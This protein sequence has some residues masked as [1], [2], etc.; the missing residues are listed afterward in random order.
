LPSNLI[1]TR[2]LKIPQGAARNYTLTAYDVTLDEEGNEVS[3]ARTDLTGATVSFRVT[4]DS[5][6]VTVILKTSAD[7]NEIEIATD[8]TAGQPQAT[9]TRGQATLK[10]VS[11]D[12]SGMDPDLAYIYDVWVELT[13]GR[14]DTIIDRSKFTVLDAV[15]EVV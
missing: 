10:L 14:A 1:V 13:D 3:R 12:T 2:D 9:D 8:Q 6:D 11:T 4:L 15:F 5:D 7:S